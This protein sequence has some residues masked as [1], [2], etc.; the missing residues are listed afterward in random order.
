MAAV[1]TVVFEAASLIVHSPAN[2]A[3]VVGVQVRRAAQASFIVLLM[4]LLFWFF[5]FGSFVLGFSS[6][7]GAVDVAINVR[8][9][10]NAK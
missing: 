3:V 9:I 7:F 6:T 8:K 1:A 5:C 4:V 2:V 10:D